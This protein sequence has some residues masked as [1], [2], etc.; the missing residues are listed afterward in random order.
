MTTS[1]LF[2]QY[3][4]PITAPQ[5]ANATV[6]SSK[7][8]SPL[9]NSMSTCSFDKPM[10][11]NNKNDN[12]NNKKSTPRY[13]RKRSYGTSR[14]S[15]LKKTFNQEQ[16][17]FTAPISDDPVVAIIGGGMSGL[18]CALNLEKRGV[19]STVFDTVG[20]FFFSFLFFP[21]SYCLI[22]FVSKNVN[23]VHISGLKRKLLIF[24]MLL[25]VVRI[26][27]VVKLV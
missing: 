21:S 26:L 24:K 19:R 4:Q 12:K 18:I 14:K 5:I 8:L 7:I 11:G 16:V 15:V 22:Y 23:A 6:F 3:L 2:S 25:N 17:I 13:P 20:Q 27:N 1:A 9:C 10:E